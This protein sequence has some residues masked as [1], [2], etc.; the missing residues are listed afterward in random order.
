MYFCIVK[1]VYFSEAVSMNS[2]FLPTD[3]FSYVYSQ[4]NPYPLFLPVK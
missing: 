2:S 3:T 1:N 4:K